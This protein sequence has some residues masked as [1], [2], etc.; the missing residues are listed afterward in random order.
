MALHLNGL[1]AKQGLMDLRNIKAKNVVLGLIFFEHI[2]FLRERREEKREKKA[3]VARDQVFGWIC[4]PLLAPKRS[5]NLE[6]KN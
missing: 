2:T 1:K 6:E 5:N 3:R 4:S